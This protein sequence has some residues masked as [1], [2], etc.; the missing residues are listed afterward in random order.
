V[1]TV[2]GDHDT[3]CPLKQAEMLDAKM[4]EAGASHTLVVKKGET[5]RDFFG[6]SVVWDFL[7]DHLNER[8]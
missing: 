7:A 5:H 4:K 2:Q 8:E 1:L 3:S 6:E